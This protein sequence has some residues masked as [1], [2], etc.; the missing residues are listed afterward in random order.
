MPLTTM[1]ANLFANPSD[2][3]DPAA[4]KRGQTGT[5]ERS[6]REGCIT[7]PSL[8]LAASSTYSQPTFQNGVATKGSLRVIR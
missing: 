6:P 8:S 7:S 5:M 4:Y 1:M 3:P 2:S